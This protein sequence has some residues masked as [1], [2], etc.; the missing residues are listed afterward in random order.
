VARYGPIE[1]FPAAVLDDERRQR[2]LLFKKLATLRID[3][4]LFANVAEL[5]W[6]GPKDSFEQFA[7]RALDERVLTRARKAADR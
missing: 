3:A 4:P 2:A 5:K 7:S 6:Q 1:E